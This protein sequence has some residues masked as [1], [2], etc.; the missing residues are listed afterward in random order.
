MLR[1][2]CNQSILLTVELPLPH[3]QVLQ[4]RV[5]CVS[6]S[7]PSSHS[8]PAPS[9]VAAGVDELEERACWAFKKVLV[10]APLGFACNITFEAATNAAAASSTTS[11]SSSSS[12]STGIATAT[13]AGSSDAYIY[14]SLGSGPEVYTILG[15]VP[16]TKEK[17]AATQQILRYYSSHPNPTL[18]LWASDMQLSIVSVR[19]MKNE[20]DG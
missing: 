4:Q 1:P 15:T 13:A 7:S 14:G 6:S 20:S 17:S 18:I 16:N 19:E 10:D 3:A 2:V 8:S 9:A 12:T 5:D 11:S